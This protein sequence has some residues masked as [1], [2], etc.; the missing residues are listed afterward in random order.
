[1]SEFEIVF[2]MQLEKYKYYMPIDTLKDDLPNIIYAELEFDELYLD[3]P[4]YIWLGGEEYYFEVGDI[5]Y[6]WDKL[7]TLL[8]QCVDPNP[9]MVMFGFNAQGTDTRLIVEKATAIEFYV[10]VISPRTHPN[11]WDYV[12]RDSTLDDLKL[13]RII[14][15]KQHFLHEWRTFADTMIRLLVEHNLI[16]PDDPSIHEYLAQFPTEISS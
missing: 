3:S 7:P 4:W 12:L 10:S 6:I 8:N 5:S 14:V 11:Y 13:Q 16:D 15:P 1:M 2:P 9:D